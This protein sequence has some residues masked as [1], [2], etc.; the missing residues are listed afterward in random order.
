MIAKINF[1]CWSWCSFLAPKWPF[2][3]TQKPSKKHFWVH[4]FS[5]SLV[6]TIAV[7]L[8]NL[9]FLHFFVSSISG[10]LLISLVWLWT[11]TWQMPRTR[12]LPSYLRK[13]TLSFKLWSL[14]STNW[15]TT[16]TNCKRGACHSALTANIILCK[17]YHEY[18]LTEKKPMKIP[19]SFLIY[20]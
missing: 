8:I 4:C 13:R 15:W 1:Y 19:R 17:R 10:R 16:K 5:E 2:L 14:T 11:F 6:P 12:F 18:F 3:E 9:C 20:T 7:L